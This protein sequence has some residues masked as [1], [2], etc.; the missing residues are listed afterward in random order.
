MRLY[1]IEGLCLFREREKKRLSRTLSV[2]LPVG[3]RLLLNE[4]HAYAEQNGYAHI[5]A[6]SLREGENTLLLC[7]AG[8]LYPTEGLYREGN[9]VRPV[10]HKSELLLDALCAVADEHEERLRALEGAVLTL[11]ADNNKKTLFS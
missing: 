7:L 9:T 4:S 3:G 2:A 11:C 5:P 1:L 10:P 6:G 8:V